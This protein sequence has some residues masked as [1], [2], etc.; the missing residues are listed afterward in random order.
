MFR[1]LKGALWSFLGNKQKLCLRLVFLFFFPVSMLHYLACYHHRLLSRRKPTAGMCITLPYAQ[2]CA[3]QNRDPLI[4]TLLYST[5]RGQKL[6]RVP[7]RSSSAQHLCIWEIFVKINLLKLTLIT[8]NIIFHL[9]LV[10]SSHA[11]NCSYF[12]IFVSEKFLFLVAINRRN[13]NVSSPWV[14]L[15]QAELYGKAA[16]YKVE[17]PF[18]ACRLGSG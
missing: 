11:D 2:E 15:E 16:L 10:V 1:N 5:T 13:H 7:F 8:I 12:H 9:F 18:A 17:F 6:H 4:K 14:S 3:Q